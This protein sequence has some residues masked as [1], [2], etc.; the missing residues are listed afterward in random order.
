MVSGSDMHGTPITVTADKEG[1]TPEEVA[2][3]FHKI[4]K[5]SIEKMEVEFDLYTSTHTENHFEIVKD[6]FTRLREKNF[7]MRRSS[8]EQFTRPA[9]P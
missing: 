6:F 3:R 7:I 9:P 2:Q 5:E 1:I 8:N 4:N